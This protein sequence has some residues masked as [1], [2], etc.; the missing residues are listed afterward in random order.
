MSEFH[1]T[2]I[3]DDKVKAWSVEPDDSMYYPDGN[4]YDRNVFPGWSVPEEG[5]AVGELDKQLLRTLQS[6]VCTFPVPQEV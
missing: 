6:I 2:V 5:S 1:Y 3:Y 4:V